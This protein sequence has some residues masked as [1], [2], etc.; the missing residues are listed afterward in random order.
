M[1]NRFYFHVNL[2]NS[3]NDSINRV[4]YNQNFSHELSFSLEVMTMNFINLF[5]SRLINCS[6]VFVSVS[7]ALINTGE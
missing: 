3:F 6:N 4:F 1:V 2:K 7:V 5:K